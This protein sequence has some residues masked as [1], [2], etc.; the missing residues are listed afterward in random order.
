MRQT[1][2]KRWW[3]LTVKIISGFYIRVGKNPLNDVRY[4]KKPPMMEAI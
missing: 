2:D 4:I 1:V 3:P